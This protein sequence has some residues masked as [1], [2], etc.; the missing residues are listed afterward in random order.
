MSQNSEEQKGKKRVRIM[1]SEDE[2]VR[3]KRRTDEN[4]VHGVKESVRT[5]VV[6]KCR[7]T[8][9]QNSPSPRLHTPPEERESDLVM[10]GAYNLQ[11]E[12]RDKKGSKKPI[13]FSSPDDELVGKKRPAEGE[14]AHTPETCASSTSQITRQNDPRASAS[15]QETD[16]DP[17][18]PGAYVLQADDCARVASIANKSIKY[19]RGLGF[20]EILLFSFLWRQTS[21]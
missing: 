13:H 17:V 9:D 11:S 20:G 1:L 18:M 15:Q 7:S 4:S 14:S 19:R 16:V 10:P 5:P 6:S 3:K 12:Q 8:S 21:A 2:P